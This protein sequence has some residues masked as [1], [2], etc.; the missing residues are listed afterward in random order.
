MSSLY[1]FREPRLE[2]PPELPPAL[3]FC[4]WCG[5]RLDESAIHSAGGLCLCHECFRS[6]LGDESDAQLCEL[7]G[8]SL[9]ETG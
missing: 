5:G 1:F 9:E 3:G 2:P 8:W 4:D 7:L 6:W